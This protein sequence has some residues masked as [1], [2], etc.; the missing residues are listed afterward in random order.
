LALID[1]R[2]FL[3]AAGSLSISLPVFP[4]WLRRMGMR[5]GGRL[6]D[7]VIPAE[8][9]LNLGWVKRLFEPGEPS[10]YRGAS[11][12]HVAMPIGGIGAGQVYLTGDGRLTHWAVFGEP[13][14]PGDLLCEFEVTAR[15]WG[16]V[17]TRRLDGTG[18]DDIEFRG[19]W[20]FGFVRFR[21]RARRTFPL[22]VDLAAWNP[23][24]PLLADVS[25]L[26]G[27]V[28]QYR[29]RNASYE[30]ARAT[31][32]GKLLNAA[33][34]LGD[35]AGF[36]AT[37][38]GG[39]VNLP[40]AEADFAAVHMGK[41]SRLGGRASEGAPP[42]VFADFEGEDYG[43]W[44]VEGEAFGRGPARGTHFRQNPVTGFEGGGLVNSYLGG[45]EP[46]G[47]LLSPEFTIRRLYVNFL[48]G[49]G[50]GAG[51][52][53][54]LL[55]DGRAA[56]TARGQNREHLE[57][58][59]WFVG[60][61][62]GKRARIAIVDD[63]SG[64]WG[65]VNVDRI[66]FSDEPARGPAE[67]AT[68][69]IAAVGE[70]GRT[71]AAVDAEG[72][73]REGPS[74]AGESW[75]GVAEI[76]VEVPPGR[77]ISANF[78][79]AWHSPSRVTA[80]RS[81]G[82]LYATRHA[83][84]LAVARALATNPREPE[85]DRLRQAVFE[86]TLPRWLV[87]RLWMPVSI[88]ATETVQIW[89]SG[90]FWGWEGVG[91]CAGTCT[92][93]WNYEHALARLW[94]SLDRSIREKQD[95][96]EAFDEETG[97][98]GFRGDRRYAADGQA[99]TILK[100][101]RAH[102]VS[103]DDGFL[104]A[105][106]PRIRKALDHLVAREGGEEGLLVG[107]QHNTYDI[108]FESANTFVGALYLAALRAGEEM[109][110]RMGEAETAARWRAVFERGSKATME[111]LFDGEYFVQAG[112][113][114][115]QYGP[116]CLAD[117]M[118]GQGWA[119]QL[120]L[121]YL[122]PVD[123]VRSALRAVWK[124]NWAPAVWPYNRAY[125][126]ER[127]FLGKDDPGL[128]LCTWPK[129]GRDAEPVRYR[130]EVWTGIE[131][132]VAGHMIWEGMLEEALVMVRAIHDRYDGARRN[133][134]N[135]IECGDHYARAMASWGCWIAL[136]GCRFDGPAGVLAFAPRLNRED[137]RAFFTAAEG[138]GSLWQKGEGSRWHHGIDLASGR[139]R[140]A[141]L[142]L[143]WPEDARPTLAR[144]R[145]GERAVEGAR[146][147]GDE[148]VFSPELVLDASKGDH[149]VVESTI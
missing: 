121:G 65:H 80:G 47:R 39:N 133:P 3:A 14:S 135:E 100:A 45:D 41:S 147:V 83:D 5:D 42:H 89:E 97:L 109:A 98:V 6:D 37:G 132:Q 111:K 34:W 15:A 62:R 140:L 23:K 120:G 129:G 141:R 119:H 63:A 36:R 128:F 51:T 88:L 57:P 125:P 108:D 28:L 35:L 84:A 24:V 112:N 33:G 87:D 99:G 59:S 78:I 75:A 145:L 17:E 43:D 22:E 101:Y 93:V 27:V 46:R 71:I 138:W 61:L 76:E 142:G 94:P 115:W 92:H 9:G 69:C 4:S 104:E 102:L 70:G 38:F 122:Y 48:V 126:P 85:T 66:V 50:S 26:P 7:R 116:G 21:S 72:M 16:R 106:W 55:V 90:R 19:E 96:G 58:H 134:W 1:R 31:V 103:P 139:L 10:V 56:R 123:A 18:F 114:P 53:I 20:P 32:R 86:T 91:C 74:P 113:G 137:F 107:S 118:F 52:R 60:D 148:I 110:K 130:D 12:R 11:L 40:V 127:W 67:E 49:G 77:E 25:I 117:Q 146:L 64:G 30:P 8:K 54:D 105:N 143:E 82:N 68:F 124:Y 29:L 144:V 44:T 79:V 131:Y 81:V 2:T 13:R 136:C 73:S 95:F 149:L